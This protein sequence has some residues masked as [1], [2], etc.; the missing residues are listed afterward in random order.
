MHRCQNLK[1]SIISFQGTNII[2]GLRNAL[3]L[4]ALGKEVLKN[5]AQHPEPIIIFLTDGE[6]NVELSDPEE[7]IKKVKELNTNK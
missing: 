3:K 2:A 7:I 6:P 5:K 1:L 4:V